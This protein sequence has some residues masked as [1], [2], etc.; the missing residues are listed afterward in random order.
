MMAT[1]YAISYPCKIP[2]FMSYHK[3]LSGHARNFNYTFK[4]NVVHKM[5]FIIQI[6]IVK[7]WFSSGISC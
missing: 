5:E 2:F 6:G 3:S 4:I 7:S 1:Q